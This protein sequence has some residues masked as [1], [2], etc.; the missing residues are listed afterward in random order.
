MWCVLEHD[1]GPTKPNRSLRPSITSVQVFLCDQMFGARGCSKLGVL[2]EV[3]W[4]SEPRFPRQSSKLLFSMS[5]S[6]T[7]RCKRLGDCRGYRCCH[8]VHND[9]HK[10]STSMM[11]VGLSKCSPRCTV[12]FESHRSWMRWA[13][14]SLPSSNI[15]CQVGFEDVKQHAA[16]YPVR[17]LCRQYQQAAWSW[18]GR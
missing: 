7:H 12:C 6:K 15:A 16:V 18:K 14:Q 10:L 2:E 4:M 1:N 9:K 11:S 3:F 5:A 13:V 8:C 17:N